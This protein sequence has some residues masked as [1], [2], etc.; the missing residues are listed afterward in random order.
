MQQQA[1]GITNDGPS[2][3]EALDANVGNV[4]GAGIGAGSFTLL[5]VGQTSTAIAVGLDTSGAAVVGGTVAIDPSSDGANTD[6]LGAWALL[7]QNVTVSSTVYRQ[8]QAGVALAHT[9][10]HV[11]DPGTDALVVSNTAPADEYS[12]KLIAALTGVT[13][14]FGA[15]TTGPTA[16]IAAGGSDATSL[17][18]ITLSTAQAGTVSGIVT[19][20]ACPT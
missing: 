5:A 20:A 3:A 15:A 14:P 4:T 11:G 2:G 6:G 18:I 12:E 19:L 9:I 7:P 17:G 1:I 13:G 16:D 10:L 8:A